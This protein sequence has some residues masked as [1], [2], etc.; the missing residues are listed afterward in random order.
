MSRAGN[1]TLYHDWRRRLR[2]NSK[3]QLSG[4]PTRCWGSRLGL[5]RG[6][7]F[8][9]VVHEALPGFRYWSIVGVAQVLFQKVAGQ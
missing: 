2:G 1:L 5:N 3:R 6:L 7:S 8:V 9:K 4:K